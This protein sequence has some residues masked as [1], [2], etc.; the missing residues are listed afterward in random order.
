[1]KKAWIFLIVVALLA[2]SV[3]VFADEAMAPAGITAKFT[4]LGFWWANYDPSVTASG[5]NSWMAGGSERVWPTADI[6]FDANN[7]LE[8][9][10]RVPN[11]AAQPLTMT[12][13]G[14]LW[15]FMWTSDL[16]KAA[17]WGDLPVDVK[18][19]FGMNDIIFGNFWYDNNGWEYEYGGWNGKA[20]QTPGS[21]WYSGLVTLWGDSN[22]VAMNW[23][24]SAGPL[25][26]H[27]AADLKLQDNAIG[28]E[29]SYMGF[30]LFA[31]YDINDDQS[32][33]DSIGSIEAKYDVPAIG[34]LTLKPSIFF[35]DAFQYKHWVFGGDL[36]VGYQMFKVVVGAT[37]T[38]QNSLAHYSGTVFVTPIDPAKIW[39]GAYLDGATPNSAPLQAVDI[40]ASY[41]FGAFKLIV[42]W[43]IGGSD[44]INGPTILGTNVGTF[45]VQKFDYNAGNNVTLGDPP[46][47]VGGVR[48]GLYFGSSIS[49]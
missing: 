49:L 8:V 22:V 5:T 28:L 25:T 35:R 47:Q 33:G 36:T 3:P 19:T 11:S 7:T 27:Y 41:K 2:L 34:D 20:T 14:S 9:A 18:V 4:M 23:A 42:G 24:V 16:T 43:V 1:M 21:N 6:M 40:G 17:G 48:N 38:D 37:S 29:A 26:F 13:E 45:G 39:I 31:A 10:L 44:Q 46:D 12:A 32:Y 15:H 30:G